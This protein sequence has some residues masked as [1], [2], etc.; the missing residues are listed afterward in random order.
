[1]KQ[2]AESHEKNAEGKGSRGLKLTAFKEI[3]K[4]K[5]LAIN[6]GSEIKITRE[7]LYLISN[8][9]KNMIPL[10]IKELNVLNSIVSDHYFRFEPEFINEKLPI[11][12]HKICIGEDVKIPSKAKH[13]LKYR[14][15]IYKKNKKWYLHTKYAIKYYE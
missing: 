13:I 1:M 6:V 4:L 14:K 8:K 12:I 15:V 2:P 9:F 11:I 10:T 7:L 3:Y 5:T